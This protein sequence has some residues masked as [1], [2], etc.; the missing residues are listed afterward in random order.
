MIAE[1]R[2]DWRPAEKSRLEPFGRGMVYC[3]LGIALLARGAVGAPGLYLVCTMLGIALA[4][5]VAVRQPSRSLKRAAATS[6]ALALS[7]AAYAAFQATSFA[8]SP[9]GHPI[10]QS[11]NEILGGEGNSI[12]VQP[13]ATASA[14]FPVMLP[15]VTFAAVLMLFRSDRAALRLIKVLAAFGVVFA[16]FG[17]LQV[18]VF[19]R[20][21]LFF[22][23]VYYL[24]SLTG[25]L[26]NRNTAGT[27]LGVASFAVVAWFINIS[28]DVA[29]AQRAGD[30]HGASRT[31]VH[32]IGA[33]LV[34]VAVA[35]VLTRSRGAVLAAV[36]AYLLI[37]PALLLD[38]GWLRA[39]LARFSWG[40]SRGG[41]RMLAFGA[42]LLVV[43]LVLAVFGS[44]LLFRASALGTDEARLCVYEATLAAFR[45]NWLFGT[46]LATFQDV[47]PSYRAAGCADPY[48]IF[49]R[50]H[51]FYLEGLQSLG[52]P[53][54]PLVV[55]VYGALA[56]IL[57]HG[58]RS[59]RRYRNVAILGV[60]AV[61][62]VTIHSALDFSL[63][64]PGMAVY[65]AAYLGAT[66]VI[67]LNR[68]DN[69]A[70]PSN[71]SQAQRVTSA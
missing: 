71:R 21:L 66:T 52:L 42:P 10:W 2:Q 3:A 14:I 50:A 18:A 9:F 39:F 35:L 56:A 47:F 24:E 11:A 25:F 1:A 13:A 59:R 53:F 8:G 46:G 34:L 63:Q 15:F 22:E 6:L 61:L 70:Q 33:A 23:K 16:A 5:S 49:T 30:L 32:L 12:S 57:L 27:L 20:S 41:Q 19:P 45:D 29:A 69:R 43:L 48:I 65:F 62:L 51:S 54:V 64:I 58:Y 68:S 36:A 55:A 37:V 31:R 67:C 60:G 4:L 17:V 40:L 7:L 28:G 44:Q 38:S 26:V